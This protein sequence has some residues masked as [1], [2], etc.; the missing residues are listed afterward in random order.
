MRRG[1]KLEGAVVVVTGGSSGVG[2]AI[3]HAFAKERC[4]VV[5]L[6]RN[7]LGLSKAAEEIQQLG[8]EALIIPTDVSDAAQVEAA[9][10]QIIERFG[11]IDIWV[12]NAMV[13]AL[14]PAFDMKPSEFQRITEVNYLGAVYGTLEALKHM[15]PRNE[16]LI[17]QVGSA[18]AYRS[19]P[20]QSA[21]C[22]TKA[23]M[24]GFTDS[25]RC[26]L[27]YEKSKVRISMLELPAVNTPQFDVG[28]SHMNRR[29][30][31]VGKIFQPEVIGQAAVYVAK[32]RRPTR[33]LVIAHTTL[34]AIVGQKFIPGL[35]DRYLSRAAWGGQM[36]DEPLDPK[37]PDNLL[38]PVPF[39]PGTHGRF[40]DSAHTFSVELF[41]RE[42]AGKLA[43]ALTVLGGAAWLGRRLRAA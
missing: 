35:L 16:G 18:L 8:G 21:Y 25:V 27:D 11:G 10:A 15:R 39:D 38:Q 3:A 34:E 5:L 24:R 40:D 4:R 6:A 7:Q 28:H 2:R 13:T 36:T 1:I 26:E 31:P 17:L 37:R 14:S 12:N 23:A 41:L 29:M 32:K 19:I 33:E 20:L 22:A 30:R 9:A 43:A 42:H